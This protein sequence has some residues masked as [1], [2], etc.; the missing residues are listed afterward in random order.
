[1]DLPNVSQIQSNGTLSLTTVNSAASTSAPAVNTFG[2][3][4]ATFGNPDLKPV[5]SHNFDLTEE[6]YP[7]PGTAVHIDA[8]YKS[9]DNWLEFNNVSRLWPLVYSTGTVNTPINYQTYTN[10]SQRTTINGVELG[11][12]TY[13][14]M[15]PGPLK[16]FGLDANYTFID[17]KNPGDVYYDINGLPHNDA[18]VAG[19]SR[20]NYNAALL[21]DYRWWSARLAYNWRSEFLLSTNTNGANGSYTYY[22]ANTPSTTNCQSPAATTCQNIKIALPV[23]SAPY[24][25]LDFGVTLRPSEHFYASF[26]VANLTNTIVKSTWGGYPG[27]QYPRNWFISDRHFNLTLGYKF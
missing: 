26:Q 1:M 8:F 4:T 11:A 10:S 17:S 5:T 21:Y 23:Y 9:I 6:W 19:L 2:G 18:P 15:L 20:Y 14:D 27:G 24:G 22:S 7:K 13:F 12:H 3:W 25:Q 16:G